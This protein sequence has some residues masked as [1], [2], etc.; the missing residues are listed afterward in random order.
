MSETDRVP[1]MTGDN[2]RRM[3]HLE[4]GLGQREAGHGRHG[5]LGLARTLQGLGL[6]RQGCPGGHSRE[7]RAE[8]WGWK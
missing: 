3:N 1:F 8:A 6:L 4:A 5:C 7:T 2:G